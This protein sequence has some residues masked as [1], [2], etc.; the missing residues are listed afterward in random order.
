MNVTMNIILEEVAI[1]KC[2]MKPPPSNLKQI[3]FM[4]DRNIP[5]KSVL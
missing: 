5:K 2:F 4:H 1:M 3:G